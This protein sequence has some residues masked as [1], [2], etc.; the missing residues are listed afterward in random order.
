MRKG[1]SREISFLDAAIPKILSGEKT[2]TLRLDEPAFRAGEVL[3][4]VRRGG[5][6]VGHVRITKRDSVA[7][8]RLTR[9]DAAANG[10]RGIGELKARLL[11]IYPRLRSSSVLARYR[12]EGR[13]EI[14]ADIKRARGAVAR[15]YSDFAAIPSAVKAHFEMNRALVLSEMPLSRLEREWLAVETARANR[16]LYSVAHHER[17]LKNHLRGPMRWRSKRL[18]LLSRL[19]AALTKSPSRARS[20]R[21]RFMAAGFT[22]REWLHAVNVVA[23]FNFSNRLAFALGLELEPDFDRS[24]R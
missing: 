8:G 4:L 15:I 10:W 22:E 17:A 16:C 2:Q 24:C 7:F 23:Y 21:T 6:P 11:S 5:E 3:R 1:H 19:A 18:G 20:L 9:A 12:F 14:F 13:S